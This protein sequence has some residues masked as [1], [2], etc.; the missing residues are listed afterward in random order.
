MAPNTKQTK[1]HTAKL[2]D[3]IKSFLQVTQ[4]YHKTDEAQS[5]NPEAA[6]GGWMWNYIHRTPSL[7]T[8]VKPQLC[9]WKADLNIE[10][11]P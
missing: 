5:P 2:I 7:S 4:Q 10:P 3:I 9:P 8:S 11:F 6:S 1:T